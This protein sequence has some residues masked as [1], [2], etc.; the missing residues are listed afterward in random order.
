MS[1]IVKF[2]F[3]IHEYNKFIQNNNTSY[4]TD[5]KKGLGSWNK[6]ELNEIILKF[7][8]DKFIETIEYDKDSKK[9]VH[10]WLSNKTSDIRKDLLKKNKFNIFNL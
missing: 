2:F 3:S 4:I 1:K 10:N 6:L 9:M 5:Y 7:G 8:L